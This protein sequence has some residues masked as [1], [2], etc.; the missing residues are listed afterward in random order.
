MTISISRT[1][2][3]ERNARELTHACM[4]ALEGSRATACVGSGLIANF[5]FA[6]DNAEL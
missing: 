2:R 3:P 1:F 5:Y 4:K 6:E